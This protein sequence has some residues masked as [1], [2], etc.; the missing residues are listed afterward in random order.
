MKSMISTMMVGVCAMV[1]TSLFTGCEEAPFPDDE[2]DGGGGAP[3]AECAQKGGLAPDEEIA[4]SL[5]EMAKTPDDVDPATEKLGIPPSLVNPALARSIDLSP[6]G[7]LGAVYV[8]VQISK[9]KGGRTSAFYLAAGEEA[10]TG[11]FVADGLVWKETM[12]RFSGKTFPAEAGDEYGLFLTS[13]DG[14]VH[15]DASGTLDS[16]KG[17]NGE[18]SFDGAATIVGGELRKIKITKT[19]ESQSNVKTWTIEW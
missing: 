9:E 14:T 18:F 15:V 8:P 16:I 3:A 7:V 13:L 5:S 10:V 11:Y 17:G 4:A 2:T 1:A 19:C 6:L 12:K